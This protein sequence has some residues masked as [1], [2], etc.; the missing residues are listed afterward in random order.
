MIARWRHS[1]L[2]ADHKKRNGRR[3][4]INT[5]QLK[6]QISKATGQKKTNKSDTLKMIDT[7]AAF[8]VSLFTSRSSPGHPLWA[9]L[10]WLV[11][12]GRRLRRQRPGAVHPN[13]ST[14]WA[15]LSSIWS[16]PWTACKGHC[17]STDQSPAWQHIISDQMSPQNAPYTVA[18]SDSG[19]TL[20][21]KPVTLSFQRN[22]PTRW[23]QFRNLAL[24]LEPVQ[25]LQCPF[26][27]GTWR[28][29]WIVP[30]SSIVL[31]T[32]SNGWIVHLHAGRNLI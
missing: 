27:N 17:C 1:V 6:W 2:A 20:P 22:D 12:A 23:D 26:S 30:D 19:V 21:Q 9:F 15:P 3:E 24:D 13:D 29:N 32:K 4:S 18:N 25:Q 10:L 16:P 5:G 8:S 28:C 7:S 31:G 11:R 14:T